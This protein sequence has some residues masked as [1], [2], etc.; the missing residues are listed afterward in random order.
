MKSVLF[1]D[2]N[3]PEKLREAAK[4]FI[5][6]SIKNPKYRLERDISGIWNIYKHPLRIVSVNIENQDIW[7]DK[8]GN[9]K[10]G[11]KFFDEIKVAIENRSDKCDF[12][13]PKNSILQSKTLEVYTYG[14]K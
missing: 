7:T 11:N 13:S 3:S 10:I 12:Y 2:E 14:G 5:I 9:I 6:K 1:I 8:T 4:N